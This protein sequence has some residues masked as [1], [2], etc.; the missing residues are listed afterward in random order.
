MDYPGEKHSKSLIRTIRDFSKTRF[1]NLDPK[2]GF[3]NKHATGIKEED[4][5]S[6]VQ[7]IFHVNNVHTLYRPFNNLHCTVLGDMAS[8]LFGEPMLEVPTPVECAS[9]V[10]VTPSVC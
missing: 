3:F 7:T 6:G 1:A 4:S 10:S 9:N 8:N 2:V 5:E